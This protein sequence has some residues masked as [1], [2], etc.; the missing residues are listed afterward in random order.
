MGLRKVQIDVILNIEY[1]NLQTEDTLMSTERKPVSI[2]IDADLAEI[3][4][5][6][7]DA[8]ERTISEVAT[9]LISF[10]IAQLEAASEAGV[11]FEAEEEEE[12]E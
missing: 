11:E 4:Q 8:H 2:E 9:Q 5:E 12:D 7:A 6:A 10:A 3:L 1:D